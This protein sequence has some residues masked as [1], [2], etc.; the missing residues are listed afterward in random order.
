MTDGF[1]LE[2][3]GPQAYER[4]LVPAFFEPCADELLELAAPAA[5]EHVLVLACAPGWWPAGW[6]PEWHR[7]RYRRQRRDDGIRRIVGG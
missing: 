1:Q 2:G 6:R 7:H 3:H 5:G 4:Y